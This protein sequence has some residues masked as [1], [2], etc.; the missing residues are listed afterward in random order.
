MAS[1]P[2]YIRVTHVLKTLEPK[3]GQELRD[4]Y[5]RLFGEEFTGLLDIFRPEDMPED[6]TDDE[7]EG[8]RVAFQDS[9]APTN[10][11]VFQVN[12]EAEAEEVT[13]DNNNDSGEDDA[14]ADDELTDEDEEMNDLEESDSEES[15]SEH[16]EGEDY[17]INHGTASH[18]AQPDGVN[19]MNV[20]LDEISDGS[21]EADVEEEGVEVEAVNHEVDEEM[22]DFEE[23][24]SEES[25]SEHEE[26]E[27][28]MINH[29]TASHHV[30]SDGV[31]QMNG[32]LIVIC[33]ISS[34]VD[35]EEEGEEVEAAQHEQEEVERVEFEKIEVEEVGMD[36]I[37]FDEAGQIINMF[38]G[39]QPE[40][41]EAELVPFNYNASMNINLIQ[42]F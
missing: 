25:G 18:H 1:T 24:D 2:E 29:G 32:D 7:D 5:K 30:Q 33:D 22:I 6:Y 17:G 10:V 26:G 3:D 19:E 23:S 31:N 37:Y 12:A 36:G 40:E 42:G 34:E 41:A 28:Y 20:D 4:G 21:S 27:D 38:A 15:A 14:Y 8:D 13:F 35:E 39:R 16:E 11:R 9:N